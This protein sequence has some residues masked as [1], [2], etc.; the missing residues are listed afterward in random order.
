M[1]DMIISVQAAICDAGPNMAG[2]RRSI[3]SDSDMDAEWS[4]LLLIVRLRG[5]QKRD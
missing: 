5:K 2:V 1:H 4:I 3:I